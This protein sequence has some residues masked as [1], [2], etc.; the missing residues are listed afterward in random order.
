MEKYNKVIVDKNFIKKMLRGKEE[1]HKSLSR[2]IDNSIQ[3]KKETSKEHVVCKVEIKIFEDLIVISDNSGGIDVRLTD[4]ELFRIGVNDGCSI[5]GLGIKK[6][7]FELGNKINLDSNNKICSRK[8]TLD[9]NLNIDEMISFCEDK[10]YNPNKVEGTTIFIS[11]LEMG[12]KEEIE[13]SSFIT[14]I[15]DNLG[16]RYSKFIIK[17]N[18]LIEVAFHGNTYIVKA[19]DIEAQKIN[20]CTLLGKYKV[21]LYKSLNKEISGVDLFIN[22]SMIYDREKNDLII[23]WNSLSEHKYRFSN[24]IVEIRF[25][26]DESIYESEKDRL[27]SELR[28]FIKKNKEYFKSKTMIIQ[29]E[30]DIDKIEYLKEYYDENTAKAI[31]IIAF[32]KLYEG[33]LNSR[34]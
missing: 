33:Y 27:Y 20:S 32:N 31:G 34:D 29:Y 15:I 11:D 21:D 5:S 8:F 2:F 7:L 19:K 25:D 1:V 4:K 22:N 13:G 16:R 10:K 18:L 28:K 12:V 17:G 14:R 24:C 23:K 3:A 26:G 30:M 9:L 6:S